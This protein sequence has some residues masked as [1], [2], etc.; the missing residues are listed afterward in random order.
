MKFGD[1]AFPYPILQMVDGNDLTQK[2]VYENADRPED[3]SHS[4]I[5]NN[6]QAAISRGLSRRGNCYVG[7]SAER[8]WHKMLVL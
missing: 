1:V 8:L 4:R 2:N 7:T 5:V 3:G 6:P